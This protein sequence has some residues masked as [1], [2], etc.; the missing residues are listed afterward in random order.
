LAAL[1]LFECTQ[2]TK[3]ASAQNVPTEA[4]G[5]LLDSSANIDFAFK[6]VKCIELGG[7]IYI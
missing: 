4:D 7:I 2:T 6:S 3:I 5:Y 1:Y